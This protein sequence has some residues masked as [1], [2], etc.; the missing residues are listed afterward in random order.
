MQFKLKKSQSCAPVRKIACQY[1]LYLWCYAI[2]TGGLLYQFIQQT[3]LC[4]ACILKTHK[5][6]PH[7]LIYLFL[8]T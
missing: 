6:A 1:K 2:Y 3:L 8:S 7:V 5:C 4:L